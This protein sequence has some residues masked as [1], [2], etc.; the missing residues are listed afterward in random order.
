MISLVESEWKGCRRFDFT[1]NGH[2]GL[3]VEPEAAAP[4]RPWVWRAEFFDAFAQADM[5]LLA[6]GWHLAYYSISDMYGCP[7]AIE[8]MRGFH[9]AVAGQFGLAEKAVL[10]G[11]SRGALYA[12][13]Y[14]LAHPQR[15]ALLYLD[16]PVLDIRSWPG[17]FGATPRAAG[18]WQECLQAYGLTEE[19]ARGFTGN[20]LDHVDEAISAGIP[21]IAVVG[22]ADSI[23]EN[24]MLLAE[25]CKTMGDDFKLI[26]KPGVGHH[27]HSLDDP[28]PIL[29]FIETKARA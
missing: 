10:F 3:L 23:A 11:F 25:R 24:A 14:A 21:I 22:D 4:G 26:V 5:A 18:E 27:P 19:T 6:K 20:P 13:N 1:V 28:A 16:G 12:F 2:T 17:G 29:A 9:D 8:L 15:V 7:A